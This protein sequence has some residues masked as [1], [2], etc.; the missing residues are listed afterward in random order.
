MSKVKTAQKAQKTVKQQY[1]YMRLKP[2]AHR[3]LKTYAAQQGLTMS[4]AIEHLLFLA[5]KL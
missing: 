2:A 5:G 4:Q 3:A 1:M